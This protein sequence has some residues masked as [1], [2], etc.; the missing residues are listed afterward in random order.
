M[1]CA[2]IALRLHG[3]GDGLLLVAQ[4][5]QQEFVERYLHQPELLDVIKHGMQAVGQYPHV[6]GADTYIPLCRVRPHTVLSSLTVSVSL[7]RPPSF[8]MYCFAFFAWYDP[9]H[10]LQRMANTA[11]PAFRRSHDRRHDFLLIVSFG[12]HLFH[13]CFGISVE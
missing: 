13:T 8:S 1:M 3:D 11:A 6:A 4:E 2:E 9:K 5:I 10:A 12:S 7:S